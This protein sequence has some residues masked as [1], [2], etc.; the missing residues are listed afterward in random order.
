MNR[1]IGGAV[2]GLGLGLGFAVFFDKKLNNCFKATA[3]IFGA[4]AGYQVGSKCFSSP[5]IKETDQKDVENSQ[6]LFE[7]SFSFLF[8]LP[9]EGKIDQRRLE[10]AD[11]LEIGRQLLKPYWQEPKG[12]MSSL[13]GYKAWRR[14]LPFLEQRLKPLEGAYLVKGK[15]ISNSSLHCNVKLQDAL[16]RDPKTGLWLWEPPENFTE[17][18]GQQGKKFAILGCPAFVGGNHFEIFMY[19]PIARQYVVSNNFSPQAREA[20]FPIGSALQVKDVF[21]NFEKGVKDGLFLVDVDLLELI[22]DPKDWQGLNWITPK[23]RDMNCY[24]AV[25]WLVTA[26][27]VRVADILKEHQADK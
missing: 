26:Y 6:K 22:L 25:D 8:S 7:S 3:S 2:A 17:E 18:V 11:R 12:K 23:W 24:L 27:L 16:E 20:K 5:R 9:E 4:L 15:K 21:P 10:L 1:K 14:S 19:D 13:Y